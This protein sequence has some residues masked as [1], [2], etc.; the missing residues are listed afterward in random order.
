MSYWFL[1]LPTTG[2]L[3]AEGGEVQNGHKDRPHRIS[4]A[5]MSVLLMA[6]WA[7]RMVADKADFSFNVAT[8]TAGFEAGVRHAEYPSPS[9][10][11]ERCAVKFAARKMNEAVAKAFK[12]A[13]GAPLAKPRP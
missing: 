9:A 13:G 10:E 6:V 3:P 8:W 11:D 7:G 5:Q 4:D 1:G 2:T 12:E